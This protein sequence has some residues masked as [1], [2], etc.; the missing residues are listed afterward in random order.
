MIKNEKSL[1]AE[2]GKRQFYRRMKLIKNSFWLK[3]SSTTE[4]SS[5]NANATE[6]ILSS[7]SCSSN[8]EI[9]QNIEFDIPHE[10]EVEIPSNPSHLT[11]AI[12]LNFESN[13]IP[14]ADKRVG[15]K[16]ISNSFQCFEIITYS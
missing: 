12:N 3:L 9:T 10:A 11:T 5:N 7:P 1:K 16:Y 15:I 13:S 4:N 2:V 6:Q 14:L 8:L